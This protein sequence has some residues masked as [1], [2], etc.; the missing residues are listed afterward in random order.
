M[1]NND[2]ENREF[3]NEVNENNVQ[4]PNGT[5]EKGESKG[6]VYT[7]PD[8]YYHYYKPQENVNSAPSQNPYNQQNAYTPP[9]VNYQPPYSGPYYNPYPQYPQPEIRSPKK[10]KTLKKVRKYWCLRFQ[11][12]YPALLHSALRWVPSPT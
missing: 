6:T 11:W 1:Y 10:K 8:G 4:N 3:N 5:N 12:F 7:T 9:R 2:N